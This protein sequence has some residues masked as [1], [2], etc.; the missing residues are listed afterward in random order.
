MGSSATWSTTGDT[1][2]TIN[3]LICIN[4]ISKSVSDE[5]NPMLFA[6]DKS[7]INANNDKDIFQFIFNEIFNEINK[8]FCSNLLT[9]NY[10]KIHF[11]QFSTK[12][13]Y[14]MNMRVSFGQKK[15]F[16]TQSLKALSLTIDTT[17]TWNKHITEVI[18]RPNKACYV[19]RSIN[20]FM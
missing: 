17:L 7:F 16:T 8:R 20:P 10:D 14:K 3:I 15:I 13:G 2:W 19:I 9:L 4:E 1:L 12:I 11:L 6:D 5:S 18:T